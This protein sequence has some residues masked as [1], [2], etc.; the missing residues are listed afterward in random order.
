[1]APSF[2]VIRPEDLLNFKIETTNLQLDKEDPDP[3]QLVV[4][5]GERPANIAFLFPPIMYIP[6]AAPDRS[7]AA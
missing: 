7:P 1:M 4:E 5:D 2:N 6:K 3:P